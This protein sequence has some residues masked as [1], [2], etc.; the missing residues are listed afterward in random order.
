M[1]STGDTMTIIMDNA[2]FI[3]EW[4]E[5]D[6]KTYGEW[7]QKAKMYAEAKDVFNDIRHSQMV[8]RMELVWD[9]Q[10]LP[11]NIEEFIAIP[12]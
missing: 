1:T 5:E 7:V 9:K 10:I 3:C 4:S 11:Q 2:Q 8:Y 12:S 6:F